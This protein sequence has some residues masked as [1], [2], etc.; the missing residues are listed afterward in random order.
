MSAKIGLEPQFKTAFAVETHVKLGIIISPLVGII[1]QLT[2]LNY[3]N[4]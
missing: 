2:I 4:H 3:I 1:I